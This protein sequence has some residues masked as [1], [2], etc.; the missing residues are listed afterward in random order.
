MVTVL[1]SFYLILP[2]LSTLS[3]NLLF[4]LR[5]KFGIVGQLHSWLR[6]VL[7]NRSQA[8][9]VST[10]CLSSTTPVTS[11]VITPFVTGVVELRHDVE[12]GPILFSAYI[13]DIVD[14]FHYGK[15]ILYNADDLKVVFPLI[16]Y[17]L[18][19]PMH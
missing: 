3:Q 9:K 1:I 11:G 5:T 8:V 17:T 2:K 4:K 12:L 15:L 10:S 13:N 19:I 14:C 6:S 16:V 18:I 7:Y